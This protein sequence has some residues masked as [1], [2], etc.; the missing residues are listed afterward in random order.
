MSDH[1]II[2]ADTGSGIIPTSDSKTLLAHNVPKQDKLISPNNHRFNSIH[3]WKT[4]F[5]KKCLLR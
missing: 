3:G 1:E 5:E 4:L 2:Y